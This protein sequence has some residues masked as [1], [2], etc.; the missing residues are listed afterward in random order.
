MVCKDDCPNIKA[1]KNNE[2]IYIEEKIQKN[3]E[4][5]AMQ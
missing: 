5:K 3:S 2:L 4:L 1:N